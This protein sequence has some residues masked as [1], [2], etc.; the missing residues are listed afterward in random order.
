MKKAKNNGVKVMLTGQGADEVFCGYR[1]YPFK[2]TIKLFQELKM[3]ALVSRGYKDLKRLGT[4]F[5]NLVK[6]Q[7]REK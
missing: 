7:R 3:L 4:S 6:A 2:Y 5:S 1:K